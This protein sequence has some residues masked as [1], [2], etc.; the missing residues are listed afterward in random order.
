M[1]TLALKEFS[2]FFE[3]LENISNN[4]GSFA[5]HPFSQCCRSG[6]G[7]TCFWAPGCGSGSISQRYGPDPDPSI[8]KQ[9]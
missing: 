1:F 8:T 3:S 5:T 7:S 2:S 9:K 4:S 6:S